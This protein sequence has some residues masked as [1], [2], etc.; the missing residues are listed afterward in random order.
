LESITHTSV[1]QRS[2]ESTVYGEAVISYPNM[3]RSQIYTSLN[4]SAYQ[5]RLVDLLPGEKN[6]VIRCTL[7]SKYLLS[8]TLDQYTALSYEW[9][10][11]TAPKTQVKLE[12]EDFA[13]TQN[14]GLALQCLR[15]TKKTQTFWID[16][17]C[18]N[19]DDKKERN[20]QVK[21]MGFIYR[22]ASSVLVWLGKGNMEIQAAFS[23]LKEIW[24]RKFRRFAQEGIHFVNHLSKVYQK[25]IIPDGRSQ[26]VQFMSLNDTDSAKRQ[27]IRYWLNFHRILEGIAS[28]GKNDP[29]FKTAWEGLA[30][31]TS[32]S[33]WT[34]IWIVQEYLLAHNV[35]IHCGPDAIDGTIVDTILSHLAAPKDEKLADLP[36]YFSEPL[37]R[38]RASPGTR[39]CASRL[40]QKSKRP[41]LLELLNACKDSKCS[42]PRDRIYAILGLASDVQEGSIV[43]DYDRSI[44]KVQMDVLWFLTCKQNFR[45]ADASGICTLLE[46]TLGNR[47]Y[48]TND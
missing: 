36:S 25:T 34:R 31:L 4:V 16:A 43:I 27:T 45:P 26:R 23:F 8:T 11:L 42:E 30:L 41:T 9:G 32:R 7:R 2:C 14:L 33:Y 1:Y 46:E 5:F 18:I 29:S 37:G 48:L 22:K 10:D 15:C 17:I 19:Q 38:I 39:I 44:F 6:S 40:Q 47:R 3:D 21:L 12:G 24:D 20:H 28:H 13:V 35:V